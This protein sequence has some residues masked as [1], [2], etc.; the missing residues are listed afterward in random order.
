MS[1]FIRR[2]GNEAAAEQRVLAGAYFKT[3]VILKTAPKTHK[4]LLLMRAEGYYGVFFCFPC[5]ILHFISSSPLSAHGSLSARFIISLSARGQ[6]CGGSHS[7]NSS[8][9]PPFPQKHSRTRTH[10]HI[11]T[12]QK[13]LAT[14]DSTI[15]FDRRWGAR[16]LN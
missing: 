5:F 6:H 7:S 2:R 14:P 16:P 1:F 13:H 11:H 3:R 9:S 4:D 12:L 8:L 15:S 10:I